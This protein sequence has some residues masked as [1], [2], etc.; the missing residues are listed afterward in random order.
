MAKVTAKKIAQNVKDG[1]REA[2]HR[3]EADGERAKRDVVGDRM[4]TTQKAKSMLKEGSERTKAA[5]DKTKR[6]VRNRS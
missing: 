4:T 5:V 3:L 2:G 6:E 1:T